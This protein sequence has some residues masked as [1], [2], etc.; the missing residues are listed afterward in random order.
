MPLKR[1]RTKYTMQQLKKQVGSGYIKQSLSAAQA[2]VG[3]PQMKR[4]KKRGELA[5]GARR[6]AGSFDPVKAKVEK[7]G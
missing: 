3:G 6:M 4:Q 1:G 7:R 5:R 2:K